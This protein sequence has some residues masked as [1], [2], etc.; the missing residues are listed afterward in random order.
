LI[1][2]HAQVPEIVHISRYFS[3]STNI[4]HR[5]YPSTGKALDHVIPGSAFRRDEEQVF[6]E[7]NSQ[8]E[9]VRFGVAIEQ[10]FGAG[11]RNLDPLQEIGQGI[12]IARIMEPNNSCKSPFRGETNRFF[13]LSRHDFGEIISLGSLEIAGI[14]SNR[15]GTGIVSRRGVAVKRTSPPVRTGDLGG[16]TKGPHV[17]VVGF[18]RVNHFSVAVSE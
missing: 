7:V 14:A 11:F 5:D 18:A 2:D 6:G 3:D 4:A 10:D 1:T 9:G 15:L 16:K 13:D 8:K 12:E 17:A